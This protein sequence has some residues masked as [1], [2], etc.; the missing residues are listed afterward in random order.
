MFWNKDYKKAIQILQE[1]IK[2]EKEDSLCLLLLALSFSKLNKWTQVNEIMKMI[3]NSDSDL[4]IEEEMRKLNAQ[5]KQNGS[6]CTD[7][8]VK[9]GIFNW[10]KCKKCERYS[11]SSCSNTS[12]S[13]LIQP[14]NY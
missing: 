12:I 5:L 7:C 11:C 13:S 4:W 1:A 10:N 6:I 14:K 3:K 9:L 8:E 2:I